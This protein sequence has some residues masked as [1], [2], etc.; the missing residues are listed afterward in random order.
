M[1]K[2]EDCTALAG[3]RAVKGLVGPGEMPAEVLAR[4]PLIADYIDHFA[5]S[6]DFQASPEHYARAMFGDVPSAAEVF[7]WQGL[8]QLRLSKGV[9]S[10]AVAGWRIAE[11]SPEWIRL[12]A[13]SHSLTVHLVVATL[14]SQL[15]LTTFVRYDH[16]F[17]WWAW[18]P[19]SAVHRR[20]APSLFADAAVLHENWRG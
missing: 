17:G 1:S 6:G 12:E 19:L 7:I 10:R 9:S 20:L 18:K 8:L 14:N 2:Q 16:R 15:A 3:K 4:S 5:L 13:Q 11:N